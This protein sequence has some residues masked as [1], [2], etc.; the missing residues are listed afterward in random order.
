MSHSLSNIEIQSLASS[1]H[2]FV[3][4]DLTALCNEAAMN[5]L[6]RYIEVEGIDYHL[7]LKEYLQSR[8][9]KDVDAETTEQI[10][11]I[12]SSL[13]ALNMLSEPVSPVSGLCRQDNCNMSVPGEKR[14]R[15]ALILEN[16]DKAKLKV[17]PSAMR[18]VLFLNHSHYAS[19]YAL[20]VLMSCIPIKYS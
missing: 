13:S 1:T 20:V 9:H 15:L 18:E 14:V 17:R 10:D 6:R 5:A 4:A 16:F 19:I 12:S 2:G 8:L 3:G 11:L 7:K